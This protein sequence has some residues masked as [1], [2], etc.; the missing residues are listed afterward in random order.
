MTAPLGRSAA[1]VIR[2]APPN[3]P[4]QPLVHGDSP[5]EVGD[6]QQGFLAGNASS[7]GRVLPADTFRD[8]RL[9]L[10]RSLQEADIR[11]SRRKMRVDGGCT[12]QAGTSVPEMMILILAGAPG[13]S[14]RHPS[15]ALSWLQYPLCSRCPLDAN[16]VRVSTT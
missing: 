13:R 6:R 3:R 2:R 11:R 15:A 9:R 7:V 16:T 4:I 10:L 14:A 8:G 12:P 5:S 1:P